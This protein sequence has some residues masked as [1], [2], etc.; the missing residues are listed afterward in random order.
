MD[1]IGT[2]YQL[3]KSIRINFILII[4]V[5]SLICYSHL[6]IMDTTV[7][8]KNQMANIAENQKNMVSKREFRG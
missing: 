8:I 3:K 1:Q 7:T 4:F 2:A 5:A 6:E